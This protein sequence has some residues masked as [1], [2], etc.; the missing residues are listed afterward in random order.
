[1]DRGGR[2]LSDNGVAAVADSM[3]AT[4][5][6]LAWPRDSPIGPLAPDW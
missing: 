6:W 5:S 3:V 1:M 4:A 2:R